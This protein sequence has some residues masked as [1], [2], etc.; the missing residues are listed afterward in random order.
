MSQNEETSSNTQKLQVDPQ[1]PKASVVG[2]NVTQIGKGSLQSWADLFYQMPVVDAQTGK[3]VID[4]NTQQPKRM[5][6]ADKV[7]LL[8]KTAVYT[9]LH[10]FVQ[11]IKFQEKQAQAQQQQQQGTAYG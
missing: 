7:G 4:P 9:Y 2:Y 6:D 3:M 11:V 8:V 10:G 5:L 1:N